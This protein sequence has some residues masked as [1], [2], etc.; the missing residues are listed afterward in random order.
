MKK[1][2]MPTPTRRDFIAT[3]AAVLG[4]NIIPRH[5]LGAPIESELTRRTSALMR[6]TLFPI[7]L[8][9][10]AVWALLAVSTSHAADPKTLSVTVRLEKTSA[11]PDPKKSLYSHCLVMHKA[12][13]IKGL[14]GVPREIIVAFWGFR[15]R[16][17]DVGAACKPGDVIFADIDGVLCVPRDLAYDV[18]LRAEEIKRN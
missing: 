10:L 5:V 7:R 18:L 1:H 8:M 13:A 4:F 11:I 14:D 6:M 16:K 17:L 12:R 3:G 9:V 2:L 15:D